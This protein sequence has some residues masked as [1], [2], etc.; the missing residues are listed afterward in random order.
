MASIKHLLHIATPEETVYKALTTIEGLSN[1][2]TTQVSGGTNEGDTITF[3]FG[4]HSMGQ[5]IT[6]LAH[7]T[8]SWECAAGGEDWI[9]TTITIT[10]DRNEE[11]TRLRFEHAG[12]KETGDHYANINFSW[13]RYLESLRQYCQTGTGSPYGK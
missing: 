13:G 12:W 8:V 2:W 4:S 5:K 7:N 6:E 10:L 11:K 3:K 1:W 9:G